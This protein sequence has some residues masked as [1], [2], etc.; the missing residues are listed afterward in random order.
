MLSDLLTFDTGLMDNLIVCG[1][2]LFATVQN[3][4]NAVFEAK[5]QEFA[6]CVRS[7]SSSTPARHEFI[8]SGTTLGNFAGRGNL[9]RLEVSE[10]SFS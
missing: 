1:P 7:L 5:A 8:D 10:G 2:T 6:S 3:A 4:E 9:M